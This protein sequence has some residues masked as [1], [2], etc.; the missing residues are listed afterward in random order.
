MTEKQRL[1]SQQ[2]SDGSS[3]QG[4]GTP[5]KPRIA[6][7]KAIF[8]R[9]SPSGESHTR[10]K[11]RS[12]QQVTRSHSLGA[13]S[14]PDTHHRHVEGT[15]QNE[16]NLST[17]SHKLNV[18]AHS[19]PVCP[20]PALPIKRS[21]SLKVLGSGD[22]YK[23]IFTTVSRDSPGKALKSAGRCENSVKKREAGPSTMGSSKLKE[24]LECEKVKTKSAPSCVKS[25]NFNG[26]TADY[27]TQ[28]SLNSRASEHLV[29][30]SS[31]HRSS[32]DSFSTEGLLPFPLVNANSGVTTKVGNSSSNSSNSTYGFNH[33][34]TYNEQKTLALD[35][36]AC[37]I[38]QD[39]RNYLISNSKC[40]GYLPKGLVNKR[41]Q[42]D[43][44]GSMLKH[45]QFQNYSV[46]S[47]KKITSVVVGLG[48]RE[49]RNSFRQAV[50]TPKESSAVLPEK[51]RC[52]Y[53]SGWVTGN[54]Q[55]NVDDIAKKSISNKTQLFSEVTSANSL[56]CSPNVSNA[57][58]DVY[59][60]SVVPVTSLQVAVAGSLDISA[61]NYNSRIQR[62][63][64][65][66]QDKKTGIQR[67]S[68]EV[69]FCE[70]VIKSPYNMVLKHNASNAKTGVGHKYIHNSPIQESR[71]LGQSKLDSISVEQ[72]KNVPV[73]KKTFQKSAWPLMEQ[74][75]SKLAPDLSVRNLSG[76]SSAA[77]KQ[78]STGYQDVNV[79]FAKRAPSSEGLSL[80]KSVPASLKSKSKSFIGKSGTDVGAS[81]SNNT[82]VNNS[83]SV[84]GR[85]KC[86]CDVTKPDIGKKVVSKSNPT[87]QIIPLCEKNNGLKAETSRR[88][89]DARNHNH[90]TSSVAASRSGVEAED[91][92]SNKRLKEV[93]SL[94]S[95]SDSKTSANKAE[96][97]PIN[98]K[99][100]PNHHHQNEQDVV[101]YGKYP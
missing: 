65:S 89:V 71:C 88:M 82:S 57:Y 13:V 52:N 90:S 67:T 80:F 50:G 46:D 6:K 35:K 93:S 8:E 10:S 16:N 66:T 21:K 18:M 5:Q 9:G 7:L 63:N 26:G 14:K 62:L 32:L 39:C 30:M 85:I 31:Q 34:K 68:D 64:K 36:D 33:M 40:D 94:F 48:V 44:T 17:S 58:V 56:H 12:T 92:L 60:N 77:L 79:S 28:P 19:S 1:I 54:V 96:N 20:Q 23:L 91:V 97:S 11:L 37:Q 53:E 49:R 81:K 4:S 70:T 29:P 25:T 75:G 43:L 101:S 41:Q 86:V 24:Q 74:G 55:Q 59:P 84:P 51:E 87:Q 22:Q 83:G 47:Q 69:S 95:D 3:F 100:S 72:I 99:L 73:L 45:K 98:E 61:S 78:L 76:S 2:S 42:S 38:W 27:N 15:Q